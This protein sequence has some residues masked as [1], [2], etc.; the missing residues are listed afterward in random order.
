[1]TKILNDQWPLLSQQLYHCT[2]LAKTAT[3]SNQDFHFWAMRARGLEQQT[4][5]LKKEKGR[6]EDAIAKI[7]KL[8]KQSRGSPYLLPKDLEIDKIC[9]SVLPE[10]PE[11][12]KE[13]NACTTP[14]KE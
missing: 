1:M 9:E 13:E 14:I 10:N 11:D 4:E 2:D 8:S 7:R 6:L 12:Q 5:G 3:P